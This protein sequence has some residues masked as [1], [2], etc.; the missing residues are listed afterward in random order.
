MASFPATIKTF[1]TKENVVHVVDADH[2]NTSEAEI[3]AIETVLG[4]NPHQSAAR[5][6]N[7]S[8]VKARMEAMETDYRL[9]TN[10]DSH[11]LLG[12]LGGDDHAQYL[13]TD[14]TRAFT[15]LTAIAGTPV[16]VAIGD[17]AGAGT[18]VL[19]ARSN[20][21]HSVAGAAPVASTVTDTQAEGS[22]VTFARSDH[23]HAREGF[24]AVVGETAYGIAPANGAAATVARSDHTHGTPSLTADT[25]V[26]HT[27]ATTGAVGAAGAP[28][29]ADHRHGMP[30]YGALG[31]IVDATG[32]GVAK[33][34]GSSD[35]VARADHSHG[36]LAE[37][38]VQG[39][40][41]VIVAFGADTP[42]TGWLSCDGVF[43]T[44]AAY[45]ALFA[46]IGHRWNGGVDPG[47]GTFRLPPLNNQNRVLRGAAASG[48]VAAVNHTHAST[49][50]TSAT[51]HAHGASA[52]AG[53]NHTH[54]I[55]GNTGTESA[56]HGH[57]I[58]GSVHFRDSGSVHGNHVHG[59]EIASGVASQ[60][61]EHIVASGAG[62]NVTTSGV[63][64]D[65]QHQVSGSTGYP[66]GAPGHDHGF[67]G[68]SGG[69]DTV[70]SHGIGFTSG[71]EASHGHGIT[72]NNETTHV[73]GVNMT[74]AAATAVP[75]ADVVYIIKT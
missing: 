8:S 74:N 44:Q 17:A 41:G 15:G 48:G 19:L 46:V 35:K 67:N 24:G 13:R 62:G 32:P 42:P 33:A 47:D 52:A 2:P 57:G 28:A 20:H 27:M 7:Y 16:A 10:H 37:V 70:H 50:T 68:W 72:V 49:A 69:R 40:V 1:T 31:D 58:G 63:N 73:H 6:T 55:A 75:T 43:V 26:A 56:D 14:G 51:T 22:A 71:G 45:P 21:V 59:V 66:A 11:A 29:R 4:T 65:H 34:A 53:S 9:L 12:G 3:T 64:R 30:G 23:R 36:S 61:H 5:A 39:P 25:P 38:A 54:W 60:N 18:G